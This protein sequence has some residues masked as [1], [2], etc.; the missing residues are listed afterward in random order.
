MNLTYS[1][2]VALFNAAYAVEFGDVPN[3]PIQE[4]YSYYS[5]TYKR[6]NF[7]S[8]A[9]TRVGYYRD[10]DWYADAPTGSEFL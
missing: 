2:A 10:G 8:D 5:E 3:P 4:Q 7:N 9:N 6:W 1:E